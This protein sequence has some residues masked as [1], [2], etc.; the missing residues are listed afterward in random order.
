MSKKIFLVVGEPS[1]DLHASRLAREIKRI[2]PQIELLG[3]GG[4]KMAA[5]GVRLFYRTDELGI[6]GLPDIFKHL[7][8]IKEMFTFI[9][10]KVEEEKIDL[11][12][13]VDYPGFNLRL[14][15][16]LKKRGAKILYYIS[17]QVW[18]WGRSR[19]KISWIYNYGVWF[20]MKRVTL[21]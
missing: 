19:I 21:A 7:K 13:L 5:E 20:F 14:A 4:D 17:P 2:D 3:V 11:V 18:A 15:K 16:A 9:L 1:G 12:I 8:K 6:I 10:T